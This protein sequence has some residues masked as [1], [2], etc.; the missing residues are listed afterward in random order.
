MK[1]LWQ[2]LYTNYD[3]LMDG[4]CKFKYL[5][6]N[7]WKQKRSLEKSKLLHLILFKEKEF[8]LFVQIFLDLGMSVKMYI[9]SS[10]KK[11]QEMCQHSKRLK[12]PWVRKP[13]TCL[14]LSK[15][16]GVFLETIAQPRVHVCFT[17]AC[18]GKIWCISLH[19]ETWDFSLK[20]VS[21]IW[22]M[23]IVL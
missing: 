13:S 9:I 16:S 8:Y 7:I 22:R 14:V 21:L 11:T 18:Q 23:M 12:S 20:S 15:K 1:C 3:N 2:R 17:V 6:T 19:E 4:P 10:D 5:L